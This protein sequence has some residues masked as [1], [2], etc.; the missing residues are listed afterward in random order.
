MFFTRVLFTKQELRLRWGFCI[1]MAAKEIWSN[2]GGYIRPSGVN[3]KNRRGSM[4]RG[5]HSLHAQVI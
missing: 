4:P 2:L 3:R 5:Q 1:S